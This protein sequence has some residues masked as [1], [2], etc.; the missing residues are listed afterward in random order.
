[1]RFRGGGLDPLSE[2]IPP[3]AWFSG[4]LGGVVATLQAYPH[5][6]QLRPAQLSFSSVI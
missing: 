4:R 6:A 5:S 2:S 3:P 1:M